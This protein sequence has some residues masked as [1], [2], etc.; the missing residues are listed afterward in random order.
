MMMIH[1]ANVVFQ[2][3]LPISFKNISEFE[4]GNN[5]QIELFPVF[6]LENIERVKTVNIR[7][8]D[9]SQTKKVSVTDKIVFHYGEKHP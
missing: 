9:L 6:L 8:F 1:F 7:R 2:F 3:F 5:L 4:P